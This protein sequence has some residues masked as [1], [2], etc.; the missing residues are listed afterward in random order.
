[1]AL[2]VLNACNSGAEK[3]REDVASVQQALPK[4][5]VCAVGTACVVSVTTPHSVPFQSV[6]IGTYDSLALEHEARVTSPVGPSILTNFEAAPSEPGIQLKSG[7][8][9]GT[10]YSTSSI[11]LW[12]RATLT[13][14]ALAPVVTLGGGTVGGQIN[15]N[16]V[17]TPPNTRTVSVTFPAGAA[18]DVKVNSGT[19]TLT[20][21]RYGDVQVHAHGRLRL[22]T[23]TYYFENLSTTNGSTIELSD[24]Q[25]PVF[26]DTRIGFD[27]AGS[28]VPVSGTG[29]AILT[30]VD[31][32][33]ASAHI[34]SD[35]HG[36]RNAS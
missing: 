14:D 11:R 24:S 6:A 15:L 34:K 17:L 27:L 13:G 8:T 7:A 29:D 33:T 19:T 32:G 21:G 35:F 16:P 36:R 28:V 25:G 22:S 26:V 5:A 31:V 10:A 1:V 23:G 20:P 3:P 2:G 18:N 4:G 30:I 9:A 12:S